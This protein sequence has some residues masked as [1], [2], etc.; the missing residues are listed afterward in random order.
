MLGLSLFHLQV[1]EV[2]RRPAGAG[3]GLGQRRVVEEPLLAC[4]LSTSR[5]CSS[6]TRCL[7]CQGAA[8][9]GSGLARGR[10]PAG[11]RPQE[12]APL[13]PW[14]SLA[15]WLWLLP[16]ICPLPCSSPTS[17]LHPAPP[18]P[19]QSSLTLHSRCRRGAKKPSSCSDQTRW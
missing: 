2:Q 14:P 18:S 16:V 9:E 10:S 7:S 3:T 8:R 5:H 17:F 4:S 19:P 1:Q 11:V 12:P 15:V 6:N 13:L